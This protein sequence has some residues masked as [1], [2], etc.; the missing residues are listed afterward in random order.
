M[1]RHKKHTIG[2]IKKIV[3]T[4]GKKYKHKWKEVSRPTILN[5]SIMGTRLK[6]KQRKCNES[7]GERLISTHLNKLKITY[8]KE[9]CI[10][11]NKRLDFFIPKHKLAIEFDGKQH[12]QIC[13]F[14]PNKKALTKAKKVD[15]E[16]TLYCINN[17]LR[18]LR[19]SYDTK[20]IESII[21]WS[22][23]SIGNLSINQQSSSS[24]KYLDLLIVTDHVKYKHIIDNVE[25]EKFVVLL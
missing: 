14:T 16:K 3:K 19:I 7:R 23:N 12:F 4:Q 11:D 22:L 2:K 21:N 24:L 10:I 13:K 1:P 8:K 15:I 9:Y 20:N 5:R 25:S 6:K 18:L 17:N